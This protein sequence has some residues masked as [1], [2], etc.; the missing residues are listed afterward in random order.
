MFGITY[1]T[2]SSVCQM[3][4]KLGSGSQKAYLQWFPFSKLSNTDA[5]T[6]CSEEFY[7]KYIQTGAVVLFNSS[8]HRSENFLQKSDG[9]FRDSSLV[10][11]ILYLLLQC[12]GKEISNAYTSDRQANIEV[13]Y[14]GNY[15]HMRP[16]YK[17]DY[18]D[19]F[20]SLNSSIENYQYFIK[21]DLTNFF[22]NI[23]IDT[24]LHQIDTVCN[25]DSRR[26]SQVQLQLFKEL[27][28]YS[29]GGRFPLIE[30]SIASS[31]LATVVYLDIID[32]RLCQ[33]IADK[34]PSITSFKMVRYVDDLYILIQSE[35]S[36]EYLHQAYNE[37]RNEYSSIL[38][39]YKLALNA[40]KCCFRPTHEIN[41]ELKKSLYDEFYSGEKA[42]IE[43]LFSGSLLKFLQELWVELF[44]DSI[45]V[46]KY[47]K[48]VEKHFSHPN[49]EFTPNE[50]FNYYVY[51]NQ[52]ELKSPEVVK[53]IADLVDQD[54]SFIS[55]DPKRLG[56]MIMGTGNDQA[57][58]NVLSNLFKRYR[59]NKWNSYDTTTA[60][61]YLVQSKFQHIDLLKVIEN[62]NKN[63]Y[64]FYEIG[65]QSSFIRHFKNKHHNT[66]VEII[67]N[68]WKTYYLYF[69][70][71]VERSRHNNM[72]SFGFFKSFFDRMTAHLAFAI[73]LDP[74]DRK[75]NYKKYYKD[76]MVQKVFASVPGSNTII[77]TAFD[78]RNANPVAHSSAGLI[79]R[80]DSEKAISQSISDLKKLI[81]DFCTAHSLIK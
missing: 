78:L 5:E 35:K 63:L 42:T 55:L 33:F 1:E 32:Q 26:F 17:Q 57:I 6:L 8:M 70:Y 2:W 23:S 21:T 15:D 13:F 65:C 7:N 51:E 46:E 59:D 18:D 45:D 72:S 34:I 3:Y 22:S 52:T 56:V 30:N 77:S 9:S 64:V 16:K 41:S 37:I 12:V 79:D 58:K 62:E 14:A 68:D 71:R 66:Y 36:I 54:I 29:G 25:R 49:V 43:T 20:K 74:S 27:L 61:S 39:E 24:L 28:S 60:I 80:N 40:N 75:P 10:S 73:T 47:N 4:T 11:P 48:L 67:S 53:E 76:K 44:L 31:Y 38:K 81:R 69:L 50:V 19:F